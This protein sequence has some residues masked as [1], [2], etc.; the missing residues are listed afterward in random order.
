MEN[1]LVYRDPFGGYA[2]ILAGRRMGHIDFQFAEMD[3]EQGGHPLEKKK[4]LPE[5]P[6]TL[7][8]F[9]PG[10][11]DPNRCVRGHSGWVVSGTLRMT[12]DEKAVD[13]PA[14][15]GFHIEAG[16]GHRAGNP[17]AERVV[18]FLVTP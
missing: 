1:S 8:A 15:S 17:F 9:E 7:L 3:W 4:R 2:I 6:I 11:V 10:F 5:A 14:G 16:T 13:Y 12:Y 18:V